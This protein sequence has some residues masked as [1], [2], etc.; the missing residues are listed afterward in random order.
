M[1]YVNQPIIDLRSQPLELNDDYSHQENRETQLLFRETISILEERE[2]WV[3]VA[4]LQQLRFSQEVGWHPYPGWVKRSEITVGPPENFHSIV[5]QSKTFSF[6]TFANEEGR[7]IPKQ[8][9]R[10]SLIDDAHLFLG[11]PYLWGGRSFHTQSCISGVDCSGLI[12]LLYR[13]Q[14]ITIPRNASDQWLVAHPTFHLLPGDPLFLAKEKRVNHVILKIS[15][16]AFIE[17]PE[18]GKPVRLLTWGKEIW[19]E[20]G[21]IHFFDRPHSYTPYPKSF[22]SK[23]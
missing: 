7:A 19:Q 3:K 20:E 9:D 18:T 10:Q 12:N 15:E 22:L 6:G 1:F 17:A 14:G 21:K 23:N 2:E 5:I 13:A 16:N 4:A 8:P 11:T